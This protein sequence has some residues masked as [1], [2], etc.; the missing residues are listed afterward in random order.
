[1]SCS[2]KRKIAVGSC[3]S[4]FVSST[5][6]RR[7]WQ[8]SQRLRRF[9]HCQCVAVDL[10]AC[11]IRWRSTPWASSRKVLRSMPSDLAAVHVLFADHVELLA[12]PLVRVRQQ[13]ERKAHLVAELLVRREAVARDADDR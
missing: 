1:M 8:L 7:G 2:S 13:R 10:D 9:E 4:T 11:A 6:S 5:N 3:I 12:H